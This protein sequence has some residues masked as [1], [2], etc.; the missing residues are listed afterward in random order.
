[1]S[2]NFY[3]EIL[4]NLYEGVYFIDKDRKITYWNN[5]AEKITGYKSSDVVGFRCC[6]NIL[7][8]T[9][10]LGVKLCFGS[11]PGCRLCMMSGEE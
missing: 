10:D 3:K 2:G 11:W 4:D 9:N 5:G 8:H 7:N 1:M 6:D